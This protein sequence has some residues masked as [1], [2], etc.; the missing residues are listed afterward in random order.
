MW[1]KDQ[2]IGI[3]KHSVTCGLELK[4]EIKQVIVEKGFILP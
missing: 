3:V 1:I 2:L 4:F